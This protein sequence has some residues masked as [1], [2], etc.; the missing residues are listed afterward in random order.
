MGGQFWPTLLNL[1]PET[2][3]KLIGE[4]NFHQIVTGD[5]NLLTSVESEEF[6][7]RCI[8]FLR[9]P[10]PTFSI[11]SARSSHPNHLVECI[12]L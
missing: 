2:A 5:P 12:K 6:N 3:G 8:L 1:F 4:T 7:Q 10:C 9:K 11:G